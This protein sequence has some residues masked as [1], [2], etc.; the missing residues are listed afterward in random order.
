MTRQ[1]AH[2]ILDK[3]LNEAEQRILYGQMIFK[4]H[5]VNGKLLQITDEGWKRTWKN[6]DSTA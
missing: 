1:E 6:P 5:F 3:C 4:M 2:K